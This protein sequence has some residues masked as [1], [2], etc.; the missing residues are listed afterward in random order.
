[1][2]V[3]EWGAGGRLLGEKWAEPHSVCS[4]MPRGPTPGDPVSRSA[5]GLIII[6][7]A[8]PGLSLGHCLDE[9]VDA[10]RFRFGWSLHFRST[11]DPDW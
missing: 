11:T 3:R 10:L 8:Y 4:H 1:M 7:G 2:G 5:A 6:S 9:M